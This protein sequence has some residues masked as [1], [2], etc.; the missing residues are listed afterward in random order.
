[1][2]GREGVVGQTQP[3]HQVTVLEGERPQ[4][5]LDPYPTRD[6]YEIQAGAATMAHF[7]GERR[8]R[9]CLFVNVYKVKWMM[10]ILRG[11]WLLSRWVRVSISSG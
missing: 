1:M 10:N 8:H 11:G 7:S 6:P 5:S 9:M 4:H 3:V 2:I